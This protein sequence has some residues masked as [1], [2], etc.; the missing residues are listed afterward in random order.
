MANYQL[1]IK[2]QIDIEEIY[3]YSILNFGIKTARKYL[4]GLHEKFETLANNQSWGNDYDFISSNLFRFEYRS[5]SI[6]YQTL[7]NDILIIRV[8]GNMQDP[9]RHF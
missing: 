4:L 3:E 6:Y 1:T 2:A 5:H 7:G 9:A 8:L